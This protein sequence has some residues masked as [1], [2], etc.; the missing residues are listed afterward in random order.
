MAKHTITFDGAFGYGVGR[1]EP[2][3][4]MRTNEPAGRVLLHFED[5]SGTDVNIVLGDDAARDLTAKVNNVLKVPGLVHPASG[6]L[7]PPN[8]RG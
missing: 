6:L 2:G 1:A 8:G 5:E 7:L 4:D 3:I